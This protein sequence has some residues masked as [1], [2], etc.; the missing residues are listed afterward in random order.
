MVSAPVAT[1]SAD[2]GAPVGPSTEEEASFLAE[3]RETGGL[4]PPLQIARTETV[5]K[6]AGPLPPLED[7]V[8][9]IPAATRELMDQLFRAKFVTVRRIPESALKGKN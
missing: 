4:P 6:E 8:N 2:D 9:Q 7:L 1:S 3:Q 5:E